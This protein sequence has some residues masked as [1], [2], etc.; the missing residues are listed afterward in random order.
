MRLIGLY[1]GTKY[2]VY[3]WNSIRDMASSLIFFTRFGEIWPWPV[4]LTYVKVIG[5]WVIKCA[6]LGCT[7]VPSM[8]SRWHIIRDMAHL[9]WFWPIF[10]HL[11]L[12]CKII[13]TWVIKCALLVCILVSSMKSVGQS[14]F[15]IWTQVKSI[16]CLTMK[17]YPWPWVKVN[18]KYII[19]CKS[20][21]FTIIP[22][23]N[24][25]GQMFL[26]LFRIE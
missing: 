3:R 18:E 1:L 8:K 26:K 15:E 12:P 9:F 14:G 4:T 21:C 6:L 25:I 11:T 23:M 20:S 10:G 13:G 5:I 24:W 19:Q 17:F 22:N 2:K 7:L 16:S